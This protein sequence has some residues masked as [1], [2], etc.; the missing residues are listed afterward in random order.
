ML[1]NYENIT[2][3][4][5]SKRNNKKFHKIISA[6]NNGTSYLKCGKEHFKRSRC[7]TFLKIKV[8]LIYNEMHSMKDFDNLYIYVTN[9]PIKI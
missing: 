9:T 1:H 4:L 2:Q 3:M 8:N 7:P 5:E 6:E